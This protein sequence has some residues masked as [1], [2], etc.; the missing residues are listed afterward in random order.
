MNKTLAFIIALS[1]LLRLI[2]AVQPIDTLVQKIILDDSFYYFSEA[3]G[4]A[5]G[6]GITSNSY[7]PTN[8]LHPLYLFTITPLSL[9]PFLKILP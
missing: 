8:G 4:L 3:K 7:D 2:I 5:T 1:F 6:H 9:E